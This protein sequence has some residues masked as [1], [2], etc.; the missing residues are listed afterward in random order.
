MRTRII[1]RLLLCGLLFS[2]LGCARTMGVYETDFGCPQNEAGECLPVDKAHDKAV[3]ES[4]GKEVLVSDYRPDPIEEEEF[5]IKDVGDFSGLLLEYDK[6]IR[7]NSVKECDAQ[8]AR[9]MEQYRTA[10]DRGRAKELHGV[11]MQERVTR[12]AAMEA[13][14]NGGSNTVP[15]RQP[16]AIMELHIMPYRTNFGALASERV[17]W[18]V[19]QEGE[20]T[21]ATSEGKANARPKLGATQ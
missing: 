2:L 12:L 15:I 5:I 4:N 16:D 18:V 3:Q 13:V 21:W 17:I 14:V 9:L 10:E 11:A 1:K 19:V 7:K 6:C 8:R 20:W